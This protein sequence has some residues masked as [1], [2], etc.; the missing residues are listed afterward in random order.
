[1]AQTT[2]HQERRRTFLQDLYSDSSSF[3]SPVSAKSLLMPSATAEA[4]SSSFIRDSHSPLFNAAS[5]PLKLN[6]SFTVTPP[7]SPKSKAPNALNGLKLTF[8]TEDHFLI[9]PHTPPH[10]PPNTSKA[11][12]STAS[13]SAKKQRAPAT[14][15]QLSSVLDHFAIAQRKDIEALLREHEPEVLERRDAIYTSA[16]ARGVCAESATES[17]RL[18]VLGRVVSFAFANIEPPNEYTKLTDRRHFKEVAAWTAKMA[19]DRGVRPEL[20]LIFAAWC[21]DIERFIPSIKCSYLPESVDKYRKQLVHPVNSANVAM[22]LLKGAPVTDLEKDRI[23]Q[24]ILRHDL[25]KPRRDIVI[26]DSVLIP[27]ATEA[28]MPALSVL[29][30]ADSFAFFESTM[31][32]FIEFKARGNSP[33][34]IW[35]RVCNNVRRLRPELRHKARDAIHALPQRLKRKMAVDDDELYALCD[36][37]TT[38]V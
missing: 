27:R 9:D 13:S 33:E 15:A 21:H 18:S 31:A 20:A 6:S 2:E 10:A 24:L 14:R 4:A 11:Q 32:I 12:T 17:A 36:I 7:N 16:A 28:L 22:C 3:V 23:Y 8:K 35:E 19:K 30:D 5:P 1:M 26:L 25:P 34:W 38:E 29:M 37:E